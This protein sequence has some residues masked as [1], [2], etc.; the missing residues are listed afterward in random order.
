VASA[1]RSPRQPVVLDTA[2][3]VASAI[4]RAKV[5]RAN[6]GHEVED[7]FTDATK[8]DQGPKSVAEYR[9]TRYAA[10]LVAMRTVIKSYL[11]HVGSSST[12]ISDVP[13]I[14]RCSSHQ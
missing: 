5:A 8:M 10:C 6:N 4:E 3:A 2:H 12:R 7:H 9:L 1:A 13:T 11:T 14:S